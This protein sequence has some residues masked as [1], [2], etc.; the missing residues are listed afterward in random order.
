MSDAASVLLG[1]KQ[2][3]RTFE[4]QSRPGGKQSARQDKRQGFTPGER[5]G[6][7]SEI[8]MRWVEIWSDLY[9]QS[10][11]GLGFVDGDTFAELSLDDAKGLAQ[12]AFHGCESI[13]HKLPWAW[14]KAKREKS[15]GPSVTRNPKST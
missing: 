7:S 8:E 1:G 15:K 13:L 2:P 10:E 9:D 3:D 14:G 6:V 11:A 12:E 5:L 4:K